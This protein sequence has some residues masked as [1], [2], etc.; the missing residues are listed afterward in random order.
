MALVPSGAI[1]LSLRCF[2]RRQLA[3]LDASPNIDQ[4]GIVQ[5]A[6]RHQ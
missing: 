3:L 6:R 4:F 5:I 2:Y 1:Q